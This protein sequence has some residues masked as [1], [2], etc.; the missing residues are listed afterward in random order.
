[1]QE[2]KRS[3]NFRFP[4][5]GNL[6]GP[7]GFTRTGSLRNK[8]VSHESGFVVSSNSQEA[9]SVNEDPMVQQMNNLR[10]YIR[11]AREANMFDE[12]SMLESNLK[13]LQEEFQRQKAEQEQEESRRR[14]EEDERVEED[15]NISNGVTEM[16]LDDSNPFSTSHSDTEMAS[17]S[18]ISFSSSNTR[19]TFNEATHQ[20]E[21]S[22]P[23]EEDEDEYDSSGKNPFAE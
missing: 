7:N 18:Y 23:F 1:M 17:S 11:Q 19:K 3:E 2:K 6:V 15:G 16:S 10:G 12:V 5:P 20:L 14:E 13:M 4:S 9:N 22:N 21:D 8:K